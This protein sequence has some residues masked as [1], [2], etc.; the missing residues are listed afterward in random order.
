MLDVFDLVVPTAAAASIM[1]STLAPFYMPRVFVVFLFCYLSYFAFMTTT[2]LAQYIASVRR[3]VG[4]IRK[5]AGRVGPRPEESKAEKGETALAALETG[6]TSVVVSNVHVFIIP[7][8]CES[9]SI[10]QKTLEK[11]SAHSSASTN[12]VAVLAMEATEVNSREK[13]QTLVSEYQT[14]FR[15]ILIAVHPAD[16]PGEARGKGSNGEL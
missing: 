6:V 4:N 15:D 14:S 7:N 16:M 5:N 2:Q 12:Y 11:L 3:I 13:A 8:Y 10:L 9:F 1:L